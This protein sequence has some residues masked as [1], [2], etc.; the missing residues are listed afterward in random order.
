[1]PSTS[2]RSSSSP[3]ARLGTGR[4]RWC[5]ASCRRSPPVRPGSRRSVLRRSCRRSTGATVASWVATGYVFVVSVVSAVSRPRCQ[6]CR[7]RWCRLV[8]RVRRW[9]PRPPRSRRFASSYGAGCSL[10]DVSSP[11][12]I[13]WVSSSLD[14]GTINGTGPVV[15]A[16]L[17]N[18]SG[19]AARCSSDVMSTAT[20][21][22]RSNTCSNR[23]RPLVSSSMCW[24]A[25]FVRRSRSARH[26]S[27]IRPRLRAPSRGPA[28]WRGRPPP[29]PRS[30]PLG[31]GGLPR[32]RTPG[33]HGWRRRALRASRRAAFSSA[34]TLI[35]DADSRAVWRTRSVSSPSMLATVSSS[36]SARP[37]DAAREAL[38]SAS[39]W[40][41]RSFSRPSSAATDVRKARTSSGLSPRREVE[42]PAS[43]TDAG[44]V[45]SGRDSGEPMP[46]S[47]NNQRPQDVA[48][49]KPGAMSGSAGTGD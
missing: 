44:E 22:A 36:S 12:S 31:D 48:I 3:A 5:R 38:S 19:P 21:R 34:R 35:C 18:S 9:C 37:A 7:R 40:R 10:G 8:P 16:K 41:S 15:G 45:G 46:R 24:R 29:R 2:G 49:T 11:V 33:A 25:D 1:M 28:V 27:R 42:N 23:S 26:R 13:A 14:A 39:S 43:A 47:V 30:A 6:S 32:P 17:T 4:R 20:N